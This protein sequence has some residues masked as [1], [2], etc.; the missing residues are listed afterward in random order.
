M[1]DA[2]LLVVDESSM[3]SITLAELLLSS[4]KDGAMVLFIGDINQL[5]SV[6]AGDVLSDLIYSGYIP[7]CQLQ[8]SPS[9]IRLT[10]CTQCRSDQCRLL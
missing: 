4:V 2:D 5:P 8:G 7:V 3:I 10:H 1:L 6:E 9:V